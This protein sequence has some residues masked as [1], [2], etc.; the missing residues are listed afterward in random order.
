MLQ[1]EEFRNYLEANS[2]DLGRIA[3]ENK[4]ASEDNENATSLLRGTNIAL[5]KD[6]LLSYVPSR[7][8]TDMLITRFFNNV[9]QSIRKSFYFIT[10]LKSPLISIMF[11]HFARR[12][13]SR[14]GK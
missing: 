5:T 14:R 3:V 7:V 1:I 9:A 11:S 4:K 6:E 8:I 13:F 2:D 10:T 12:N